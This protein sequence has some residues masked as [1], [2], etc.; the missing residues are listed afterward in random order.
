MKNEAFLAALQAAPGDDTARL[1]YAD[2]LDEQGLPGGEFLRV[3][4]QLS[5]LDPV[6]HDQRSLLLAKLRVASHGLDREWLVAVSGVLLEDI[7]PHSARE[8]S[9]SEAVGSRERAY[10]DILHRG[11]VLVRNLAHGGQTELCRIEADHLHNIPSLL[12]ETNESPHVFYILQ[13]RG[14]YLKRLREFGATDYLDQ[15][16]IWYSEPW[17]VLACAAGITR[18]D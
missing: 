5:A 17:W 12:G 14:L 13:E 8:V 18:A 6:D 4:C 3:G 11:L 9:G 16:A 10:L 1:V 7:R 15:G 2:W